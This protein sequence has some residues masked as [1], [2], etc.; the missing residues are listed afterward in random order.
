M[1]FYITNC[2]RL[3]MCGFLVCFFFPAS[4]II[5]GLHDLIY[6]IFPHSKISFIKSE[7][8]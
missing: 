3:C 7:Y 5:P 1:S 8:F 4:K 6:Y 2:L